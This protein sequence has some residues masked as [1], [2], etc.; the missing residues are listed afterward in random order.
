MKTNTNRRI[1]ALML[2]IFMVLISAS[3]I[4][5][6][7]AANKVGVEIKQTELFTGKNPYNTVPRTFEAWINLITSDEDA[8]AMMIL[9][10]L[11]SGVNCCTSF[12][13]KD[14]SKGL[15]N[16]YYRDKDK[17]AFRFVFSDAK[18]KIEKNTWTHVAAT[19][20]EDAVRFYKN[21]VLTETLTSPTEGTSLADLNA[22]ISNGKYEFVNAPVLG[23]DHRN[24]NTAY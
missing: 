10:D 18:S 19:V 24:D 2:S 13:I 14:A 7:S 17:V 9:S 23:G 21:G 5:L 6:A 16:L 4:V 22:N 11:K 15:M 8:S 3:Q 20:G 1:L 12:A